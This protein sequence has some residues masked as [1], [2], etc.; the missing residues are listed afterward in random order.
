MQKRIRITSYSGLGP[1]VTGG[2]LFTLILTMIGIA[3]CQERAWADQQRNLLSAIRYGDHDGLEA[4]LLDGVD[5]NGIFARDE[6]ALHHAVRWAG[7]D[8]GR[9]ALVRQL[10]K[11]GADPSKA[12]KNGI[13]PL[14]KAVFAD[15][16]EVITILVEGG[17]DPNE[18]LPTGMSMLAMAT[19]MGKDD[20]AEALRD[21]GGVVGNSPQDSAFAGKLPQMAAFIKEVREMAKRRRVEGNKSTAQE[22]EAAL[23]EALQR[24]LG[25]QDGDPELEQF[26]QALRIELNRIGK[27]CPSCGTRQQ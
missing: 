16:P 14:A 22:Q 27:D 17:A 25:L 26:R 4:L 6:T 10:L 18:T 20:A 5:P 9:N 7:R 13:T 24:H 1:L 23:A 11:H 3:R 2:I 8:P 12:D 21:A 19:L 15:L